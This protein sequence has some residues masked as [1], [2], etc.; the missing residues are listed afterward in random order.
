MIACVLK[1]PTIVF[2]RKYGLNDEIIAE[3]INTKKSRFFYDEIIAEKKASFFIMTKYK[4]SNH[5]EDILCRTY[6]SVQKTKQGLLQTCIPVFIAKDFI[7][8]GPSLSSVCRHSLQGD[9]ESMQNLH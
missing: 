8:Q 2:G 5:L 9:G 7:C 4:T 6:Y 3:N 1:N